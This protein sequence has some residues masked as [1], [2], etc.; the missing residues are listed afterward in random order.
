[1]TI[2]GVVLPGGPMVTSNIEV[3]CSPERMTTFAGVQLEWTV[4]LDLPTQIA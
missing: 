3:D 4:S 1:M 2:A